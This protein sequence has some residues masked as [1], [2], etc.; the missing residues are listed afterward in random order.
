MAEILGGGGNILATNPVQGTDE[1]SAGV[2]GQSNVGPGVLGQSLG[3][4]PGV[5]PGGTTSLARPGTDG[6]LGEGNNGV[7]GVSAAGWTLPPKGDFLPPP[8]PPTGAGVWGTNTADGPGVYGTSK[9]SD[10]VS[11]FGVNGV[12]GQSSGPNGSGV[13]GTGGGA[14][15]GAGVTGLNLAGTGVLGS[16]VSGTGVS[17][18]SVTGVGVQ[19]ICKDPK[20]FAAKFTGNVEIDGNTTIKGNAE[21]DGATTHGGDVKIDGKLAIAGDQ[22]VDG[23]LSV[24]KDILLTN[25]DCAEEFNVSSESDIDPG[26]VLSL[27]GDGALYPSSTAY[28]SRV[29]GVVSGA[30][31]YRP[32]IVLDRQVREG[33]RVAVALLGK[34]FCKVDAD[35]S[36][37]AVGD[38]LTTAPSPGYA[39]K[40]SDRTRSFGAVIGKALAPLDQGRGLIPILVTLR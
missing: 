18:T 5:G 25:G 36:P 20:G 1:S 3:S 35:C 26:T 34:V 9:S 39:M 37:V 2:T 28:D 22:T 10:G 27:D 19:G 33:P 8:T 30:G 11:G 38:L 12:S 24:T 23:T 14:G 6:V 29:V 32:A 31:D 4:N 7:R 17:G 13:L 15:S 21:I 40:A 16:D